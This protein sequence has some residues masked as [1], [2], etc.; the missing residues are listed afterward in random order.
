MPRSVVKQP[1]GKYA[2]WSSVVDHFV[3]INAN[4]EDLS[5]FFFEQPISENDLKLLE[6]IAE[7]ADNEKIG[8]FDTKCCDGHSKWHNSLNM[9]LHMHGEKDLCEFLTDHP[10][11]YSKDLDDPPMVT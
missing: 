6:R 9:I 8:E 4:R 10:E 5:R 7:E 1:N 2:I 11:C 3:F